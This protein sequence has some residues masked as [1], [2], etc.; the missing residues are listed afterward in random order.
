LEGLYYFSPPKNKHREAVP[1][2]LSDLNKNGC[3]NSF[4]LDWKKAKN[5]DETDEI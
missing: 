3:A 4:A 2:Q 5:Y 1:A